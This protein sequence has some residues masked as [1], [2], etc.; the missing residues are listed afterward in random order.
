LI[1]SLKRNLPLNG[2]SLPARHGR[3]G[4]TIKGGAPSQALNTAERYSTYRG[5]DTDLKDESTNPDDDEEEE[6]S[7]LEEESESFSE[8]VDA[9]SYGRLTEVEEG[10]LARGIQQ[11]TILDTR[12]NHGVVIEPKRRDN[13]T[14]V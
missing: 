14:I 6:D 9:S 1:L 11:A 13:S 3:P 12:Q 4:R 10:D 2:L 5:G 8:D 7:S